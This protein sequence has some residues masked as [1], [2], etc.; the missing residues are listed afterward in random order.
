MFVF[1]ASS[2]VLTMTINHRY[3]S[4]MRLNIHKAYIIKLLY[5]INQSALTNFRNRT[6]KRG[7]HIYKNVISSLILKK[8]SIA[9][10]LEIHNNLNQHKLSL[11]QLIYL[12]QRTILAYPQYSYWMTK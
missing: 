8:A 2:A 5:V 12:V 6:S 10:L 1:Y 7:T 3:Y 4:S 11:N 9:I